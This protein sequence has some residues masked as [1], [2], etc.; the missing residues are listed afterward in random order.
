MA[1][2]T[3]AEI[4]AAARIKAEKREMTH[5]II[6][7]PEIIT[8]ATTE[9]EGPMAV[10]FKA[11]KVNVINDNGRLYP[12]EVMTD[13]VKRAV[14]SYV[15]TGKMVGETPHPKPMKAAATGKIIFDTKM[16]NSVIKGINLFMQGGEVFLDATVLETAKGKDL[17]ALI[18]QE[19]PVGI[20]MRALGD[21]IK[22]IINGRSVDV[23]TFLDIQSFDV[24]MNPATEGCGVVAVLTDAQVTEA[25]EDGIVMSDPMC[26][27]CSMTLKPV[28]PDNDNDVDFYECPQCQSLFMADDSLSIMT[29]ASTELRKFSPSNYDRYDLARQYMA[30]KQ[31]SGNQMTDSRQEEGGMTDVTPEELLKAMQDPNVRA[32]FA[33]IA[34]ETAK[35]ALDAVAAQQAAEEAAKQATA[36]KAEV[37]TFMDEKVASLK[38]KMD[39]K[40]I[41]VITDTITKA[42]P[43]TKDQANV[44]FDAVLKAVSDSAAA[45]LLAGVG[46]TG[47]QTGEGGHSRVESVHEP[48]PWKPIVDQITKA[49]DEY[50]EQFGKTIDPNLRKVNQQFVDKILTRYEEGI[51]VKAMADSVQGF[52]NLLAT[53]SVSVTTS[54]LLNQPTILTA[55][56]VQAFQDVESLQ[57]M[58]ADVFAGQEWRIPVET[59][60][61]AATMNTATGLMDILVPEG[62]GIPESAINLT[63]QFYQPEWRRNAVSLT[64]DV[65]RQLGDGPARYEAI[66]RAIYHIGEDK[67]RKLDNAAYYEMILASDEYASLVIGGA[68]ETAAALVA[69]NNGTNVTNKY[70]LTGG[71]ALAATAGKNPIV[72]PRTKK[73]LQ[74]DGSVSSVTTNPFTITVP[75]ATA[76]VLGYL[77]ASGNIAGTGA[78]FAVDWENGVVYF[79]AA[80]TV[81]DPGNLPTFKYS[82]VTN[83]DSWSLTVPNGTRP[84]DHYNTL[85]QQISKTVALMGS[86]PRYKKPNLSIFSL[87]AATYIENAQIFYKLAQ[88]DGTRLITTGNYFGERSG[89]N[90]AKINAPWIVGDGRFLLT[91]KGSTRYGV[92]TPY[93]IEG[94]Y[95]KYDSNHQIID[96]KVWYGRENSVLCTPQVTD[97]SGKV[98]NPVSRTIKITT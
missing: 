36:A 82:A 23:A 33:A 22:R 92:E 65:V 34:T 12:A 1:K 91:Q 93:A 83:Y 3:A 85:L 87:N 43:A 44:I 40:S 75:N 42:D 4:L 71:G 86:S 80:S 79:N 8:D 54:Q 88:P 11:T 64:T 52:E 41:G 14:E 50:G 94:P 55:V 25:I 32:A 47:A 58:M 68:G 98:I 57:F 74:A 84:E 5:V 89:C 62:N 60:T 49:F 81:A 16:E 73:Q 48:K 28:D 95:P 70:S 66:A 63:W 46:F 77:D 56:L 69:V 96:A 37:K 27:A 10:R 61:S 15:K 24:V 97:A 7:K 90:F 26:P 53:D 13:A 45:K 51:G 18:K 17:K 19:I 31:A 29:H 72:R 67:R 39:D 78:T 6:T 35:P 20:S 21:S 30:A 59:F 38:G 76:Q 9:T 2:L